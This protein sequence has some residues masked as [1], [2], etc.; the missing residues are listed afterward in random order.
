MKK[1]RRAFSVVLITAL[2][3]ALSGILLFYLLIVFG[4]SPIL[5]TLWI[6]S[7]MHTM[8]HHYLST[9]FFTDEYIEEV[10]EENAINDE[11]KNSDILVFDE[12]PPDEPD[13]TSENGGTS[14]SDEEPDPYIEEGYTKLE[15]GLY[16]KDIRDIIWRGNILLVT[17]PKRL[18]VVDTAQQF[19]CGETVR[20]MIDRV[21]GIAGINGG[22]FNDG[23][24]YDSNGGTPKGLLIEDGSLVFPKSPDDKEVYHMIGLN[25]DG[26]L[27]L[28]HCTA[29]WALENGIVG[30]VTFSPFLIVNG[31]GLVKEGTGG[32]G[33]ASRTAIGQR[34]TGEIILL[35]ID[36]RQP[37]WSL[38]CDLDVV[39][40]VLL[41]EKVYNA[42]LLDGGS[43]TTMIYRDEYVNQPS[44]GHERYINNCF[45]VM[46]AEN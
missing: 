39:Q 14:S 18:R 20:M 7:S 1:V 3:L 32:W 28:R 27:I 17:D 2:T 5:Q 36:G 40:E 12:R 35:V 24:N 38:G 44:L 25:A 46:P 31:E 41:N 26:A 34:E 21:G 19:V 33:I 11:Y 6:C 16:R 23:E 45:V 13:D 9:M 30:C 42:A 29:Q 10:L 37:E 22:A 8:S 43:S 4:L 15:D